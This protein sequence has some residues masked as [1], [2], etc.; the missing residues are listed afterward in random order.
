[1]QDVSDLFRQG[2][3]PKVSTLLEEYNAGSSQLDFM[4]PPYFASWLL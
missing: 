1:M 4:N 3:H 2:T